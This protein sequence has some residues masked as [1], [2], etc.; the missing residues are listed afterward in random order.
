[1]NLKAF[2][3]IQSE[4]IIRKLFLKPELLSVNLNMFIIN[5][6]FIITHLIRQ[7]HVMCVEEGEGD[8]KK[9]K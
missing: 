3:S 1:M 2:S 6:S 7:N 4:L 8:I 5:N 9:F